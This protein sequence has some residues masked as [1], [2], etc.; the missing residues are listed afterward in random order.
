MKIIVVG[1]GKIGSAIIESLVAEG[2]DITAIDSNQ[3]VIN[4]TNNIYDVMG[5]CGN[6]VDY[7]ILNEAA[8]ETAELLISVT[9]SDEVNMLVCYIAK[10]MGAKYTVARVRNPEYN[11]K[12]LGKVKQ[13]LDLALTINPE[14]L[15]AQEIFNMIKLPAAF[16]IETFSH[17][18]F[19]MVELALKEGSALVGTSLM[20]LRKKYKAN[21]LI[22]I[23]KRGEEI[24]IPDGNFEL[25]SGDR[26]CIIANYTEIQKLL[27]M[28][29][30]AK[31]QAKTVMILGASKTSYY[32]AK[33]L[34][35]SGNNVKIIEKDIEI[36]EKFSELL[37]GAVII[38][39][40]G[41]EQEVLLEE[42]INEVDVFTA[43][44]GI[45][46]ENI[47]V[48]CFANSKDVSRVITKVS[49][50]EL[51]SMAENLG[52]ESVVSPKHAVSNVIT[53]YARAL[54]NSLGSNVETLYKLM[55]GKAEALEFKVQSDFKYKN[56][57]LKDM[58][59]K[60]DVLIA[61]IIR[62]RTAFIPSGDDEIIA[63]DKVVVIAKATEQ[64]MDDLS[65]IMR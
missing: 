4:D 3:A 9:N 11:D 59:L 21:F 35:R 54:R 31:K 52:L 51:V 49:R 17:R 34:L 36:C 6:A 15:A 37:P 8:V 19:E 62:K 43:L 20:V 45:D 29:G 46:E 26:I 57:P 42:G 14:M 18:S 27:K 28:L 39:G 30:L 50:G 5:V 48:S 47:L 24:Y 53:S 64:K 13:Y 2:H 41:T 16:N 23:V 38:N 55:N 61:G 63:G 58:K 33:M 56:I 65:D 44:T 10:K 40:D 7:D 32:L 12:R 22:S 60:K 1:C 25:Q